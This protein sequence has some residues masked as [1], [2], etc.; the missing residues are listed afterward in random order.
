[1]RLPSFLREFFRQFLAE[2]PHRT[3]GQQGEHL[4]ARFLTHRCGMQVVARNVRVPVG[5]NQA[6][7]RV[8]GELD[9]VAFDGPTLVF[10]EVKTRTTADFATPEGLVTCRKRDRLVRA[11]RR[12]RTLIGPSDAPYRFDLVSLVVSPGARPIVQLFKDF[13][14]P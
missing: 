14:R 9:I 12:Y 3:L 13:L 2:T 7:A 11:A 5:R 6:G 1:M 4:A 8:Y 10:V